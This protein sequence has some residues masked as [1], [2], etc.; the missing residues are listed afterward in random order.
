MDK[1]TELVLE[2][3]RLFHERLVDLEGEFE[4]WSAKSEE[5]KELLK[6]LTEELTNE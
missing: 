3:F 1:D 4:G 5:C 2:L 6:S